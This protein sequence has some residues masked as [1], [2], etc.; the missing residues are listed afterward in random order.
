MQDVDEGCVTSYIVGYSSSNRAI[1]EI[2]V[3]YKDKRPSPVCFPHPLELIN[4]HH[5]GIIM[6][7]TA[8]HFLFTRSGDRGVSES[9]VLDLD[10]N[11][12]LT[13][14]RKVA[15]RT[16]RTFIGMMIHDNAIDVS[17][18]IH[19]EEMVGDTRENRSTATTD[20]I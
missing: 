16:P 11:L 14:D 12:K 2:Q 9:V 7:P 13:D 17:V 15:Q 1:C 10:T 5:E 18:Y 19:D 6:T 8:V 3:K 20:I 4:L